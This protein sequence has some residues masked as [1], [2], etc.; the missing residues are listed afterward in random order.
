MRWRVLV[1]VMLIPAVASATD[2]V[3][4]QYLPPLP[5]LQIQP[6]PAGEDK[7]VPL[8]KGE[9]A[10][11]T[12]QL[13]S[14]ETALRWANWLQQYQLQ[15]PLLLGTQRQ[16]CIAEI[17]YRDSVIRIDQEKFEQLE[18]DRMDRIARLEEQN[19]KLQGELSKGPAWYDSRGFGIVIGTVAT[20]GVTVLSVWA[21][22]AAAK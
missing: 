2:P 14:P 22:N 6:I 1:A 16:V 5:E 21:L 11:Y 8:R 17:R 19:A 12:G 4:E 13:Y 18:K 10:P 15:T 3:P 20:L 7:I 9:P